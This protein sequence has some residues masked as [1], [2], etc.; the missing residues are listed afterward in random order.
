MSQPQ[1]VIFDIGNVLVGWDPEGYYDARIGPEKRRQFFAEVPIHKANVQMDA[2]VAFADCI[3]PLA[4]LHPQW[5]DE[6]MAWQVDLLAMLQPVIF[7]SVA[8][9]R[10]LK[11]KGVPVFALTNWG[12]EHFDIAARHF[13]FFNEFDR[14]FVSARL[15]LI[16]PD[17]AIY[18]VVERETGIEPSGLLFVDDKAENVA[19]AAFR[20]WRVHQFEGWQGWA[21]RLVAEGL[22]TK[23]EAGL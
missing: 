11:R 14:A 9:M 15:G 13:A 17:P 4:Q 1:A 16:K 6:V 23:Q 3:V 10:A 12:D 7:R 18:A 19:A 21:A 2:G 20:G 8:L 22:L 5:R